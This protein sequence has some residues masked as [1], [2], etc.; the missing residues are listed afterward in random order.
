[1]L[2]PF[3]PLFCYENGGSI[4]FEKFL[5]NDL[6]TQH[7]IPEDTDVRISNFMLCITIITK[8]SHLLVR[9][10][11]HCMLTS[12]THIFHSES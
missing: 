7:Y 11:V 8:Y 2:P 9:V 12:L 4:S 6:T 5:S 3:P 1:M 10:E